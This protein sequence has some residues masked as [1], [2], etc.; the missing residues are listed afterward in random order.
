MK[1]ALAWIAMS[2]L[3]LVAAG[4]AYRLSQMPVLPQSPPVQA[5]S[6]ATVLPPP[7]IPEVAK[8]T[9]VDMASAAEAA[10]VEIDT[11]EL[12]HA[13]DTLDNNWLKMPFCWCPPG[14]FRMG[15]TPRPRGH[16][17]QAESVP[18]TLTR[19][20]WMG[21]FEVTQGQWLLVIGK[22]VREQRALDPGQPRPVGD[23]SMRDHVGEG[24]EYPIYFVSH[25]DAEE[26]CR[27]LSEVERKAGRLQPGWEYRL[28][29]EA[30]WEFACRGGKSTIT[31]F[32]DRL[33]SHEA[34][35]DGTQPFGGAPTGPYF[36][37]TTRVGQYPANPWG[38][39]D[40]NGNVWELCRD[41]FDNK[42]TGGTDPVGKSTGGMWVMRG[43]CWHNSGFDCLPAS[44]APVGTDHRGSGLGFRV[45]L[46]PNEP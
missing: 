18:V 15:S 29:T 20:F 11:A 16:I 32:G 45:A 39:H 28:P 4:E 1:R 7:L 22:S 24:P 27:K 12:A 44:R 3:A 46:V 23:G 17:S 42:L 13:G 31:A 30:Q 38:I 19:G 33:S 8:A 25:S 2:V 40:M 6:P 35:F 21:K 41:G 37:E 9:P 34:N 26:F 14:R 36:H 43:G 5:S 10:S